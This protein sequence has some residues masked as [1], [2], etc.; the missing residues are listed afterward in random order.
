MLNHEVAPFDNKL[1]RQAMSYAINRDDMCLMA[2]D[3]LATPAVTMA[4]PSQVFGATE[5]CTVFN[6]D[7]DKA[8]EL[9]A[10]AGYPDGF[11]A[12]TISTMTGYFEKVAQV[13]Q[14]N[15]QAVGIQTDIA[16]QESS[17]YRTDCINGNFEIAVMGV[18]VGTDYAN[19]R[20]AL[21]HAVHRQP[22]PGPLS[23]PRS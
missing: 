16:M 2:L 6:Y 1:V 17:A 20:P 21:L 4:R 19:V 10:E 9:L 15:L 23:Q 5:D 7:P 11:N 18:T 22:Q 8:K 14:S 3:G 12:G 13:A